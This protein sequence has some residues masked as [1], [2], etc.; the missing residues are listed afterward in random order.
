MQFPPDAK[1]V[2]T[3]DDGKVTYKAGIYYGLYHNNAVKGFYDTKKNIVTNLIRDPTHY[4]NICVGVIDYLFSKD[5]LQKEILRVHAACVAK[6]DSGLLI[7]GTK[8]RGKTTLV[9]KFLREGYSFVADDSVLLQL[10]NNKLVVHP[11]PRTLKINQE[12]LKKFPKLYE[13][14]K[15]VP[16]STSDGLQKAIINP[17]ENNLPINTQKVPISQIII[18]SLSS[19]QQTVT[20]TI[21]PMDPDCTF[22]AIDVVKKDLSFNLLIPSFRGQGLL[23]IDYL[24][25]PELIR[26]QDALCRKILK[27]YELRLFTL[28]TDFQKIDLSEWF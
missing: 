24:S 12:D 28:G 17:K 5:L 26:Q 19:E 4:F 20:N 1:T 14:L 13:N 18:P 10:R 25:N 8:G 16:V 6:G 21:H 9:M 27:L 3:R 11:F 23:K 7:C 2:W 22:C 15:F